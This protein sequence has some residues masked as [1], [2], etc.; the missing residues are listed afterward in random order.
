MT[1]G[2]KR[3]L[4]IMTEVVWN[5][6]GCGVYWCKYTRE[7]RIGGPVVNFIFK[8][9]PLEKRALVHKRIGFGG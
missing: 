3:G 1:A 8:L 9:V 7:L 6:W 5:D 4:L 2:P